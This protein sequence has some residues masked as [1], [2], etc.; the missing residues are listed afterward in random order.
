MKGRISIKTISSR[1]YYYF[2]T[3]EGKKVITK[4]LSEQEARDLSCELSLSDY[5]AL[6]Q[7]I[8]HTKVFYGKALFE[9]SRSTSLFKKRS[10]FAEISRYL[11]EETNGKVLVLYG[12]RRVGKT[13]LMQ[14]SILGLPIMEFGKAAY[15]RIRDRDSLHG[16]DEDLA[17]LRSQGFRYIFIDEVTLLEDF[18]HS[19]SILSDIYGFEMKIVLS[20]TDSLGF[21]FAKHDEL[22]DRAYLIHLTHIPFKEW[23]EVLGNPSIEEYI[24]MGGTMVKEGVDYNEEVSSPS[25]RLAEYVDTSIARN[26]EHSLALYEDGSHFCSLYPLYEKKELTNVINRIV[27]DT[28][29]RLALETLERDFK[30]HD[31][32]SLRN[33]LRKTKE[34]SRARFVLD[35]A[36]QEAIISRLMER[37]EILDRRDRA[38][39]FGENVII[40]ISEYLQLLD[41][42]TEVEEVRF[43]V[44]PTLKKPLITIPGLRYAQAK[45]LASSLLEDEYIQSLPESIKQ[46]VIE[47]LDHDVKGRMLEE[48][49]LNETQIS[50]GYE[51]V[52]KLL[53]PVGE[54]DMVVLDPVNQQ[55]DIF[56]IKLS[57]IRDPHQRIH[58]LDLEMA[59]KFEQ[60]YYPIRNR[61]VLYLGENAKENGVEYRNIREYL[62]SL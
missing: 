52:F 56:E 4:S 15:I 34:P 60:R 62:A 30:S 23:S 2:Q 20:G 35:E 47:K 12:I 16:L 37:L 24:E 40:E 45:A 3:R 21:I 27:E 58:L 9:F 31:Y 36:D 39:D 1:P 44:F 55:A 54:Y 59:A 19:S 10:A 5:A 17:Y 41:V 38:L 57:S 22:Y 46:I 18:I 50:C 33:L 13:T 42:L 28:N 11:N 25:G 51:G 32:G 26:I 29:H 48:I 61:T 8:F 7:H 14:Q 43:G 53:F 6:N 49:V